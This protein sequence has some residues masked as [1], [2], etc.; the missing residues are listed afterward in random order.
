MDNQVTNHYGIWV[1]SE[2]PT[3]GVIRN[4]EPEWFHD[5]ICYKEAVN[6][7]YQ[8]ALEEYSA[9]P[10]E[11]LQYD[12]E[13]EDD[14]NESYE[15]MGQDT[16][17]VGGWTQDNDGMWEPD[18]SAEYSAIVGETYAQIVH[19]LYIERAALCS[20][21][22][23]GQAD[24]GS[25]GE[26]RCFTLPLDVWGDAIDNERKQSI[27]VETLLYWA[28]TFTRVVTDYLKHKS[29]ISYLKELTKRIESIIKA[30]QEA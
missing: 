10:D 6:L 23:P 30:L 8:E 25:E 24:I 28:E 16:I 7:T 20:P 21:C 5:E 18:P 14:F 13:S 11:Y 17:L 2:Q 9:N 15:N 4:N 27:K 19:S 3:T 1:G 22:Y 26:Y 12:I 29:T